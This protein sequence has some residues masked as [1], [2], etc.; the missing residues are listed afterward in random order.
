MFVLKTF[1][2][3]TLLAVWTDLPAILRA[4]IPS[5]MDI[6]AREERNDFLEDVLDELKG[7]LLT[8]TENVIFDTP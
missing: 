8:G 1:L 5:D 3:D 2:L 4:L 7:G 6:F